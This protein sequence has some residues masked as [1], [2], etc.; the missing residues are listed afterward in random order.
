MLL[1]PKKNYAVNDKN[2]LYATTKHCL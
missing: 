2:F 1:R